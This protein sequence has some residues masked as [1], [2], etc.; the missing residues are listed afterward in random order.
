MD[1]EGIYHYQN[2]VL[3]G[4]WRNNQLQSYDN[5]RMALGNFPATNKLKEIKEDEEIHS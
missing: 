3:K 4:L 2:M 1:G 5:V